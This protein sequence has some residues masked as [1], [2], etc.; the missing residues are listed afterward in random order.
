M[1]KEISP[2]CLLIDVG[3]NDLCDPE[4]DP[5]EF[6][7]DLFN[8]GQQIVLNT[9]IPHVIIMKLLF[10]GINWEPRDGQRIFW[11]TTG[12]YI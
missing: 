1:V 4:V 2:H 6:A 3:S 11:S 10:R 7:A 9:M 12:L 5:F 8:F